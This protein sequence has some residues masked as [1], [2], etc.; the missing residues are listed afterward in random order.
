[1]YYLN[2]VV[3]AAKVEL[4]EDDSFTQQFQSSQDEGKRV[5]VFHSKLV[6]RQVIDTD[7]LSFFT[8]NK[9]LEAA[10]YVGGWM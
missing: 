9:K 5:P 10:G 2:E 4:H 1:M 7:T 3:C 8:T 6:K